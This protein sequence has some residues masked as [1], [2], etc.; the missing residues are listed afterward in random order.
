M[1]QMVGNIKQ[2]R[3]AV[4][5]RV[6]SEHSLEPYL[7]ES[8]P[9]CSTATTVG[10]AVFERQIEKPPLQE[11]FAARLRKLGSRDYYRET[12]NYISKLGFH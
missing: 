8:T 4:F 9:T 2:K 1:S 7:H 12:C 10:K 6:L 11:A 3:G 5:I